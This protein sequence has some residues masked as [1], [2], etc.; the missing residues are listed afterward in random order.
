MRDV[1]NANFGLLI[2]YLLPGFTALWGISY[3]SPAVRVWLGAGPDNAPTVG[4]FLYVT[5]ASVAA[6]MTVSAVRW[7]LIDTLH[8]ITGI[9]GP[10]WD[11][12]RLQKNIAAFDLIVEHQYRHYQSY[13]GNCVALLFVYV[14]R[15][16]SLGYPDGFVDSF[17]LA[18]FALVLIFFATSRDTYRRYIVRGDMF[19]GK[20]VRPNPSRK[21]P[22][23]V[24]GVQD[25][26]GGAL[27]SPIGY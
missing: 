27:P 21:Q 1:T 22:A 19:L 13:S 23:A 2:A 17:D 12:G 4:G 18:M 25:R 16:F 10:S 7:L 26:A 24:T 11:F 20:R 5:V 9:A 15:H 14:M 3:V 8:H 6:G